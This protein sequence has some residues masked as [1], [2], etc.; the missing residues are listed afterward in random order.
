MVSST[1]S[2]NE[3]GLQQLR[4]Q[5]A[6]RSAEQAEQAAQLLEAQAAGAQQAAEQAQENARSLSVESSQAQARAGQA[7]QGLIA[8]GSAQQAITQLTNAVNQAA[9]PV[10]TSVPTT[11]SVGSPPPVVNTQGQVTGKIVNTTA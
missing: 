11:Q 7:R 8:M 1:S 5:Q 10:T 9:V 6:R 4:V 2:A 3:Y